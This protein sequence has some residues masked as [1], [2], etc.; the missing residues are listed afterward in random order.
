[1][2]H[3]IKNGLYIKNTISHSLAIK[4]GNRHGD[5]TGKWTRDLRMKE[6]N[7]FLIHILKIRH[8]LKS[9]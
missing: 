2:T 5:Q 7:H 9:E 8:L 6:I 3:Y 4:E 1:M